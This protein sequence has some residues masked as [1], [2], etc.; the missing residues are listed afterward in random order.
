MTMTGL[1]I[2]CACQCG[3]SGVEVAMTAYRCSDG[4]VRHVLRS[5]LSDFHASQMNRR[6]TGRQIVKNAGLTCVTGPKCAYSWRTKT[7]MLTDKA[8]RG[9]D[10]ISVCTALHEVIHSTQ[11]KWLLVLASWLKPVEW[12][13]ELRTWRTIGASKWP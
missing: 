6:L 3:R 8:A 11:P 13:I 2:P 7:V 12:W 1:Q 10:P 9:S 5:H 4:T